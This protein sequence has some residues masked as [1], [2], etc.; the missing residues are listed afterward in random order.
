[1]SYTDSRLWKIL[2]E[3]AE[4]EDQKHPETSSIIMATVFFIN[5]KI[6]NFCEIPFICGSDRT[7]KQEG[8][9]CSR[10]SQYSLNIAV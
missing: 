4:V 7:A 6:N 10:P 9:P 2:N 3:K 1:M 5:Y 8:R